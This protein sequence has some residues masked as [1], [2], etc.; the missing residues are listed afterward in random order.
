MTAVCITTY[1]HEAYIAQ[2]IESVRMQ[3]CDEALR[4]YIGDDASTDGT[5]AI[6][7]RYAAEDARIVYVRR[8]TNTGLVSNTLD[9]YRRIVSDG[10][11]FIAMLDGDD[12]WTDAHKIEMQVSYLRSHPEAGFVHTAAEG[13]GGEAIPEGDLSGCYGLS[14]ARQTNCTVLFRTELLRHVDTEA[15]EAQHF[16]VLDY[17]LYGLFSQYTR[18]AYIPVATA[19]WREHESVSQPRSLRAQLHYRKERLRMWQWL[20]NCHP[21][22]FHFSTF[23]AKLWYIWQIF[24]ILF[25]QIKK[26]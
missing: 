16:P 4:I 14:G 7:E 10:C 21:K 17:P 19:A 3:E 20:D 8:Q 11:E 9:L 25:A 5:Q 18:F 12:Y 13:Q 15:I 26:K 1:N 6:C 22:Q 2:A 23:D 24:Y